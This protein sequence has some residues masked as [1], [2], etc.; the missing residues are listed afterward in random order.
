[1]RGWHVYIDDARPVLFL[2]RYDGDQPQED[3]QMR[4][5]FTRLQTIQDLDEAAVTS[6]R[7]DHETALCLAAAGYAALSR[8]L[9]LTETAGTDLYAMALMATWGNAKV[10]A[11][12]RWLDQLRAHQVRLRG[13]PGPAGWTLDKWDERSGVYPGGEES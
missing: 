3:D 10:R 2:D 5:W 9:D 7:A 8:T 11:W 1:V 6:V 4:I 12:L 13:Q